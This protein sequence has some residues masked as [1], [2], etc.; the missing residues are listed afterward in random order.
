V[1]GDI[2]LGNLEQFTYIVDSAGAALKSIDD[3]QADGVRQHLEVLRLASEFFIK[4][5]HHLGIGCPFGL[6]HIVNAPHQ[7]VRT[8]SLLTVHSASAAIVD[9]SAPSK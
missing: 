2:R 8:F 1:L 7:K 6:V 9:F 3:R 5:G 4:L